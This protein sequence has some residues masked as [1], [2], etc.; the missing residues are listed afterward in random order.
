MSRLYGVKGSIKNKINICKSMETQMSSPDTKGV[1]IGLE[2]ALEVIE[3]SIKE[4]ENRFN[5]NKRNI[6]CPDCGS[7]DLT[8][9]TWYDDDW[10]CKNCGQTFNEDDED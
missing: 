5:E 2:M 8:V 3:D 9:P 4:H 10:E 6:E 7:K 1:I